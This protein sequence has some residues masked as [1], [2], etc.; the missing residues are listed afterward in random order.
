MP[1]KVQAKQ[2]M[3]TPGE[4]RR[5]KHLID[6]RIR[7][8]RQS[9]WCSDTE[10]TEE[11][12]MKGYT[13]WLQE[14]KIL[15]RF[16][17][18]YRHD[19]LYSIFVVESSLKDFNILKV[20][21]YVPITVYGLMVYVIW[22]LI[23]QTGGDQ[24]LTKRAPWFVRVGC[25]MD[26]LFRRKE[27]VSGT[28]AIDA[29]HIFFCYFPFL[30]EYATFCLI[31]SL[32]KRADAGGVWK[33]VNGRACFRLVEK[34]SSSLW[35]G[36]PKHFLILQPRVSPVRLGPSCLQ[37]SPAQYHTPFLFHFPIPSVQLVIISK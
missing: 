4:C 11:F 30:S 2:P 3:P 27:W 37:K 8:N 9:K 24:L 23:L 20:F 18:G 13:H 31:F 21:F 17:S 15:N 5:V 26:R 12:A 22:L 35:S 32:V 16:L 33:L 14:A 7:R 34:Y 25:G 1:F 29:H 6:I 10:N 19:S 28:D 36:S